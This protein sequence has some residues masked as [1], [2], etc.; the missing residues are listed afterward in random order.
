MAMFFGGEPPTT[1][2]LVRRYQQ[3]IAR[4]M[5]E[6]DRE[7]QKLGADDRTL[8]AEIT[9]CASTNPRMATQKAQSVVR[10]RKMI[11][12]FSNMRS[13]LGQVSGRIANV[14]SMDALRT[15]LGHASSV[16]R[17]FNMEATSKGL[18]A[19]LAEF[20]KQNMSMNI[21]NE[22][23]DETL[24]EAFDDDENDEEVGDVVL[25]V[26]SQAGVRLPDVFVHNL[27]KG[28]ENLEARLE[29]LR[30]SGVRNKS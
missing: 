5:R 10:V 1:A 12:R 3:K 2:E 8:M 18:Q 28:E 17:G 21:Q 9:R 14:K 13:H 20:S 16:M 27:M 11:S 26:L 6:I 25:E 24:D 29:R 19:Q 30:P 22:M 7:T 23:A 15:S 4:A